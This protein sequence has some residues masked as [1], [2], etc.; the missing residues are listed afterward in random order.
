MTTIGQDMLDTASR[1]TRIL[2][3][4]SVERIADFVLSR[5]KEDGG[6]RGR[7]D[8]TD[9]YYTIFGI[10]CLAVLGRASSLD[11]VRDY[12]ASFR[13]ANS[14]DF[15]HLSCLARC[16]AA[17]G[18]GVKK[19]VAFT[20]AKRAGAFKTGDGG[21]SV[22]PG[23]AHGSTYA[24]F[25]A[26][27]TTEALGVEIPGKKG[28]VSCVQ[29]LRS[30]DGGYANEPNL[31]MGTTTATA[32]ACLILTSLGEKVDPSVGDWLLARLSGGGF[33][34]TPDSPVPDLLSTATALHALS[35]LKRSRTDIADVC[36]DYV[37]SLWQDGGGFCGS[38]FDPIADCEYTFY[39]LLSLGSLA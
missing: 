30:R 4:E 12:V 18:E 37:E 6:F 27:L 28:V 38:R 8:K 39:A 20:I 25:L 2:P 3:P 35:I 34:G 5:I 10:Q 33:L 29:G 1:V 31:P 32:A 36:V 11:P 17:L 19:D 7:A 13:D 16:L 21:Y 24:C 26:I 22:K 14:L 15:V 9:L 23:A